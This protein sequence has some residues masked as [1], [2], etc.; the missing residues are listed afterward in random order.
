MSPSRKQRR[1]RDWYTVSV[2]TLRG[3]GLLALLVVLAGAGWV[4][5][6][7]WEHY[8]IQRAAARAIDD[9]RVLLQQVRGDGLREV[10]PEYDAAW[11]SLE[12]ARAAYAAERFD[13]A[14]ARATRSREMLLSLL[15]ASRRGGAAGEAQ[16]IVVAGRVEY[17][18]GD[19]DA[20]QPAR[21][22]VTLRPGDYVKTAANGSAEIMF[23]D[24]TLYTVRPDTLFLVSGRKEGERERTV[25]LQYGWIDLSTA[26]AS[27]RVATPQAQAVVADASEA[28][29][30]YDSGS[31]QG[32]FTAFRGAMEV[33]AGG[34]TRRVAALQS[35]TQA[36]G[37]LSPV[38]QLP[39]PPRLLAP[40]DN[41]DVDFDRERRLRLAWQAVQGS[42]RYAL[43]VSRN[44]LFVDNVI[45]VGNRR[46]TE[47]TLGVEG[48]GA[49]LWRVAAYGEGDVRG[50]WSP[51]ARFRVA[52]FRTGRSAEDRQPP[53]LEIEDVQSYGSI[54]IVSGKTEP[55]A[56]VWINDESVAVQ[57][58]GSF[59]KTIQLAQPG[60]DFLQIKAADA[61]GNP[62]T[63]RRRVFVESL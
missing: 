43:Q 24:G 59:T 1:E 44:R 58:D 14:L 49:F 16:F 23:A 19:G 52:S 40:A 27:S 56:A 25:E 3:W 4:G 57:A 22:R 11:S 45:D 51:P 46:K 35:V 62:T 26:Q 32:R 10:K 54:F 42:E 47:A 7:L 28:V 37:K 18:R 33:A 48:E 31:R 53:P 63:H 2:E 38:Q 13:D 34:E 15:D 50:P 36:E 60:W 29:V 41:A 6:R 61:A 21:M 17:R 12:Q 39:P 8:A 55:G 5:F 9:A 20:W 30:S